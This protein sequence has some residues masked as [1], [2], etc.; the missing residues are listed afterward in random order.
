MKK[1][2]PVYIVVSR[3][4][5]KRRSR[6]SYVIKHYLHH[7]SVVELRNAKKHLLPIYRVIEGEFPTFLFTF[8]SASNPNL[9]MLHGAASCLFTFSPASNPQS[10]HASGGC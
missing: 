10:S 2:I 6:Y 4:T 3:I 7:L 5:N 9:H 8:S 1:N